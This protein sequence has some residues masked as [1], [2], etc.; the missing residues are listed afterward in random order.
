MSGTA[1]LW[2]QYRFERRLFWRNPSAAFFNFALPLIFLLLIAS[3]FNTD[4]Q[5]LNTLIPGIAGMAVMATTFSA[6][7]FNLTFYREQGI[8]KRVLGTPLPPVIYF[9]G[10][11]ANAV[12]NAV[13]QVLLIVTLGHLLYGVTWPHDWLALAFFTMAGVTAFGAL[14]IAFAQVI[15]N[16]DSAPAYVNAVFLPVIFISGVFYDADNAPAFLKEVAEVLPLKHLIDGLTG[17]MVDGTGIGHHVG[18]LAV[19]LAWATFGVVFAIRGFSWEA[20]R[21]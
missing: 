7:A 12:T 6:L 5:E 20:K 17:A 2:R 10:L 16:F 21:A 19:L 14:G 9:G 15:P 18:A 13:V 1:L 8:L 3:V 4:K 11:I